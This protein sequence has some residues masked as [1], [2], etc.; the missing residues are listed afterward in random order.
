MIK[1]K[2][3]LSIGVI[4]LDEDYPAIIGDIDHPFSF[5]NN[6]H[7]KKV[8]GLTFN[9][10]KSGKI[11]NK[12][13]C[14]FVNVIEYFCNK[15]EV[16]FI[17]GNCGF[18]IIFQEIAT[19]F[20]NKPI[21]LSPLLQLNSIIPLYKNFEIIIITSNSFSLNLLHKEI[22]KQCNYQDINNVKILGCENIDGFEAITKREKINFDK[23]KKNIIAKI[24]EVIIYSKTKCFLL[25][26]TQLCS[27]AN[28]I[29]D[30]FCIPVYDA[31]T[32]I[33]F[34]LSS[35]KNT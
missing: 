8:P 33:N 11:S 27:F 34:I 6:V 14:E 31:F 28:N 10:C 12:I 16:K 22:E 3:S 2:D 13:L 5:T 35:L 4:R 20:T 15:N 19:R 30:E 17:I 21:L 23:C 9:I 7:Y 26:C 32:N 24:K 29:R 25:E 1:S 18:M